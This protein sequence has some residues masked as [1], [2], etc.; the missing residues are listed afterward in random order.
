VNAGTLDLLAA[1]PIKEIATRSDGVQNLWL[2]VPVLP[3]PIHVG[4]LSGGFAI[5]ALIVTLAQRLGDWRSK[6]VAKGLAAI[7]IMLL[8]CWVY[9]ACLWIFEVD[10]RAVFS[11]HPTVFWIAGTL[12]AI[13]LALAITKANRLRGN[14]LETQL[15]NAAEP[16]KESEFI[17]TINFL[18]DGWKELSAT[19]PCS[20]ERLV[21][22]HG[23]PADGCV[24]M[25][26][27]GIEHKMVRAIPPSDKLAHSRK[28]QFW[29][30]LPSQE[31][32]VYF[33]VQ[34][35]RE[36]KVNPEKTWL[37][38]VPGKAELK[39]VRAQ[40]A[41]HEYRIHIQGNS[42]GFGFADYCV[43]LIHQ[44]SRIEHLASHGW[45]YSS[46]SGIQVRFTG[47]IG[48]SGFAGYRTATA[49]PPDQ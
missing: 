19:K 2:L 48:M 15:R 38:C 20:H 9:L 31:E 3:N 17:G 30:T 34:T 23:A 24:R 32:K 12:S 18:D 5:V 41:E 25:D 7:A 11:G 42:S 8:L 4:L 13:G 28:I 35:E 49:T 27:A 37:E 10:L 43:D 46:L 40:N 44:I 47:V 26:A 39:P 36:G 16:C 21:R 14:S 22:Y 29:A 6:T 1:Q 45:V 33:L